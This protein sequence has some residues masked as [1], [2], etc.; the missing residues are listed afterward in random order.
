MRRALS[1]FGKETMIWSNLFAES[2]FIQLHITDRLLRISTYI[3]LTGWKLSANYSSIQAEQWPDKREKEKTK[4]PFSGLTIH[5]FVK[6]FSNHKNTG[7][8]HKTEKEKNPTFLLY[9]Y[10]WCGSL[11]S[12]AE[13]LVNWYWKWEYIVMSIT[14]VCVSCYIVFCCQIHSIFD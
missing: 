13:S 6:R 12:F 3:R 14:C 11:Y 10:H 8:V 4:R 5:Y 9:S 2:V 1:R 7:I